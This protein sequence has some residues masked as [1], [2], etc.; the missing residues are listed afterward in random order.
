MATRYRTD[1]DCWIAAIETPEGRLTRHFKT[2]EEASRFELLMAGCSL[3]RLHSIC[4]SLDWEGK[5]PSQKQRA[6]RLIVMLGEAKHP[7]QLTTGVIDELVAKRRQ[8]GTGN[9]TIRK[10]LSALRVMLTRAQRLGWIEQ[11]PL[12]PEGRT[13]KL[14]E[15]RDLVIRDEWFRELLDV[16]EKREQRDEIAL[17]RF[18]RATGCRVGEA[19][20]LRWDRVDLNKGTVQFVLTKGCNARRLPISEEVRSVLLQQQA[21]SRSPLVFSIAYKTFHAQY[22]AAVRQTCLNLGLGLQVQQEWVIHT[23]RH[24]KITEL[25]QKGFQAPAIQQW[26]GHKSLAITQRYVHGAGVDLSSLADC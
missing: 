21:K 23:L 6:M 12:F 25:A 2:E 8:A 10:E 14:P 15:A 16:M 3:Y 7:R 9:S 11:L 4:C 17:T 24:T 26:A 5:E 18:L 13:L 22:K 19:L 20:D 1:R